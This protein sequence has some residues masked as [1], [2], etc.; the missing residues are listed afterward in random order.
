MAE[1]K[2]PNCGTKITI[3]ES[4]YAK[5]VSQIR[6]EEFSNE[7]KEMEKRLIANKNKEIEILHE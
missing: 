2:C 1:I 7:I 4:N 3:D 5:I 6:N